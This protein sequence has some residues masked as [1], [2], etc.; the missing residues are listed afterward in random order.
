[1]GS[2]SSSAVPTRRLNDAKWRRRWGPVNAQTVARHPAVALLHPR[3]H[4]ACQAPRALAQGA[5]HLDCPCRMYA[6]M[7]RTIRS[8]SKD[9][10]CRAL[11]L[12]FLFPGEGS[13]LKTTST[14]F[15]ETYL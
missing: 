11:I 9:T 12:R 5:A 10:P 8:P 3:L 7:S 13:A 4:S 2:L 1:M 14:R 6:S 15:H